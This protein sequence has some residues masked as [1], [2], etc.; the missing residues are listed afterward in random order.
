MK[1]RG[2][3]PLAALLCC[4]SPSAAQ[5]IGTIDRAVQE[6]V[7][8]NLSL[9][10]ER[11]NLTIADAGHHHRSPAAEP[12]AVG[13]RQQPRLARHRLRRDQRRRPAASMRPAS[14]CRS[15]AADKRDLRTSVGDDSEDGRRS[16]ARGRHPAAEARRHAR[17][18]DVLE[19]KAKLQLARE[20]LDALDQLVQLNERRLTS[21][22]IP[23]LEADA[24]AGRDAPVPRQRQDGA[25][26]ARARRG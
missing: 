15:S 19:A 22:A 26:R 4:A 2:C 5:S 24:V 17:G 14:M 8:H 18:I 1:L 20:N 7:E 13:R 11:L 16:A 3:V 6:A 12:G 25:A 9:L 10:A 23:P 21:G